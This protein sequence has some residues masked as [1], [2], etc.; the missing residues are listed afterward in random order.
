MNKM[1]R[2]E[3]LAMLKELYQENDALVE[4]ANALTEELLEIAEKV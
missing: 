2:E 1:T 4:R 3:A